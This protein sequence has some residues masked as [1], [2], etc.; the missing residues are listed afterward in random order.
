ME[1][2]MTSQLIRQKNNFRG[3]GNDI[4]IHPDGSSERGEMIGVRFV[5]SVKTQLNEYAPHQD[6]GFNDVLK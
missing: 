4:D 6:Q 5:Q 2:P 1:E 3:D